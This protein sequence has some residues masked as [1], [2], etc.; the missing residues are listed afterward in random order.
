MKWLAE[1]A[2]KSRRLEQALQDPSTDLK[3][4]LQ[5]FDRVSDRSYGKPTQPIQQAAD[6]ALTVRFVHEASK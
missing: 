5:V 3:D 4:W 6:V 2:A 1:L